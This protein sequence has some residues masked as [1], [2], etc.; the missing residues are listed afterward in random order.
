MSNIIWFKNLS[1][2]DNAEVGGKNASLGEMYQRLTRVGV[3]IPN[4]F[5]ITTDAYREFLKSNN[6]DQRINEI[7]A[8]LKIDHLADLE[9]KSQQIR[10]LILNATFSENL[11]KDILA[12]YHKLSREFKAKNVDVA[13]RSSATAEDMPGASFAG[14]QETMLNVVGEDDLLVAVKR[15]I[16]SLFLSRSISYRVDKNIN[17]SSVFLSVGVQKMVRSDKACSGIIFTIDPDTGFAGVVVISSTWGLGEL[18]V[19]G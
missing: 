5:A 13:V 4:G 18:I 3:R 2:K 15:C 6:L 10:H 12:A 19:Q 11:K 1:F 8:D 14:Q 9:K 16:A 17:H 7:L